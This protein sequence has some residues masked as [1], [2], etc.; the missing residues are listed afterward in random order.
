MLPTRSKIN[1]GASLT[2]ACFDP[3][4]KAWLLMAGSKIVSLS[5]GQNAMGTRES[6]QTPSGDSMFSLPGEPPSGHGPTS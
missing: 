6:P 1:G 3:R 2:L 4:L 5:A